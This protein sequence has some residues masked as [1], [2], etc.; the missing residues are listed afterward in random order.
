ML[1]S[2]IHPSRGR[3][4]KAFI[5][6]NNWM[7]EAGGVAVEH[8]FS[9]DQNDPT[10]KE[11]SNVL[12]GRTIINDNDCVVQA[13]NH[14]AKEAKGDV[15]IYLSDD[16]ECFHNWGHEIRSTILNNGYKGKFMIKANDGLQPFY[17]KVLTI[18][19][20]S[21]EL[22]EHLGYFFN[23]QYK[24]MWVDCDLYEVCARIEGCLKMHKELLF[25]HNHYCNGK[26]KRDDT[27][28]RSDQHF[29]TGRQIFERRRR[30]QFA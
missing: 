28:T 15:L 12:N 16:F 25:Q 4:Q 7:R 27:Y 30:Q 29:E 17:N 8:I 18:P 14:A 26:S 6:A 13:T 9:L 5:T 24:S 2:L 3:P 11:Y 21:R 1:I 19:I 22:Y 10:H 23:P 20:M